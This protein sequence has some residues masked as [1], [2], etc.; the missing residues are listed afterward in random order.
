MT[1]LSVVQ[2]VCEVVGVD[3]PTAVFGVL[4]Y[5]RTMQEMLNLANRMAQRIAYD[6]R[7][8]SKFYKIVTYTGD[9]ATE[10]F[11]FPVDYK[12]MMT[13]TQVWRSTS[14]LSPM[15]FINDFD[16]WM[17]RRSQNL[18][19]P[20]GEWIRYGDQIHF[21]PVLS[22]TETATHGYVHKNCIALASGGFGDSFMSDADRFALDE[23]LLELGMIWQ[24]KAD[25]GAAY[26]E[27]LGTYQ[28]ALNRIG[29]ADKPAPILI[30]RVPISATSQASYPWPAPTP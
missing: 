2:S 27:D 17:K 29:G 11:D 14:N 15:R 6:D 13:T 21:A 9:G 19:D 7:D 5:D 18:Y 1:L 25:K 4:S 3:S 24:W 8:W 23:R 26:Q 22:G 16:D 12:R 30:G 20:R 10:A 28:D